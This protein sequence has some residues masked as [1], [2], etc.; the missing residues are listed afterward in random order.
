MASYKMLN[1]D[2]NRRITVIQN[3]LSDLQ[4]MGIPSAFV[5][6]TTWTGG[7]YVSG[8]ERVAKEIKLSSKSILDALD[9][10]TKTGELMRNFCLPRL[11]AKLALLN[12]KTVTNMLV[13]V[14]KD[15]K[16][17]WKGEPPEWWPDSVPFQHPRDAAPENFKGLL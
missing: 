14:G 7:L 10:N 5:Y 6:V 11:P 4:K 15:L 17:Q 1:R 9:C 8:D 3:K 16:I 13:G 2:V 12:S